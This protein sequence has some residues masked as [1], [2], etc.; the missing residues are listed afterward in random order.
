MFTVSWRQHNG[1]CGN[2]SFDSTGE[3]DNYIDQHRAGWRSFS[4]WHRIPEGWG[5][6]RLEPY[7]S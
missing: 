4:R 3:M 2:W 7:Q 6:S 1:L 5:I